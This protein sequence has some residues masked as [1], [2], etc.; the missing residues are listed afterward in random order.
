MTPEQQDARPA[1]ELAGAA[2]LLAKA[3]TVVLGLAAL[4]LALSRRLLAEATRATT[5][6]RIPLALA[7]FAM[8]AAWNWWRPE[9]AV[10]VLVSGSLVAIAGLAGL[11][12]IQRVRHGILSPGG[13]GHLSPFL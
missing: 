1:L 4:R 11:A 12:A 6:W 3:W 13:D 7:S 8:T 2:W 5:V 9:R 10:E